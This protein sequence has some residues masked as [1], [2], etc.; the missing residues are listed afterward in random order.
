MSEAPISSTVDNDTLIA[1]QDTSTVWAIAALLAAVVLWGASFSAMR[2]TLRALNPWSVM[3]LRMTIAMIVLLPFTGRVWPKTYRQGDWKFL[4]PMVLF[5]PC[6]YFF[7]ESHALVLT[8]S[9]QA[10]VISASVPV[11][12]SVGAWFFLKESVH[13]L[14]FIGF[15]VAIAGVTGLTLM[16]AS[17][18]PAEN[19]ILGNTL[20]LC[21]M[22]SAASNML[23][24]KQLSRRYNPWT[25]TAM[26]TLAGFIFFLPGLYYL[27]PVDWSAWDMTMVLS[28]VFL[29]SFVTLGAFGLYNWGMSRIPASRAATFINL[30]P[31]TAVILGWV[32]LN[33]T[34]TL[35]QLIAAAVVIGGV[36]LSQKAQSRA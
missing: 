22:V 11:M 34:L 8:T 35:F 19:P 6:L 12:V 29:G 15:I 1:D 4:L 17:G 20:E 33:E 27:W 26:Q 13:K 5:Q 24:V 2:V 31:V 21:A 3:W 28:M 10:G 30:V 32:L 36:Y 25:L 23:I 9:S 16:Q 7:L 18:G 14:T